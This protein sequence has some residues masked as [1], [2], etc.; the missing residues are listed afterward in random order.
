MPELPEVET[1]KNTL[2]PHLPG[3]RIIDI[4]LRWKQA[5]KQPSPDEFRQYLI[6]Q[7]ISGIRRRG[8]Y[9]LLPLEK[10]GTLII[11]LRMSG[12]LLLRPAGFE[13]DR[14][15]RTIFFLDNNMELRFRDVRK[16]GV[17]YLVK[18]ELSVIGKLGP[19]PLNPEFTSKSLKTQLAKHST[20]IKA[21]LVDQMIIAGIGNMYADEILHTSQIHPLRTANSLS[22]KEITRIYKAIVDIL[23]S[24]IEHNGASIRD[25][26]D[27]SGQ[28]GNAQ[29]FFRVAH[30][31]NQPCPICTTPVTRILVR[32]RGTYFCPVCQSA[33]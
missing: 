8:K 24:A 25:Y 7:T 33:K 22:D 20:N 9:L 15:T 11:H 19:E 14:F 6:G 23:E 1:I 28:S 5:V 26:I 31:L 18:D 13:P 29:S 3:R 27:P 32:G 10:G 12:S 21:T 17:L 2:L 16:L 30:R 4:E